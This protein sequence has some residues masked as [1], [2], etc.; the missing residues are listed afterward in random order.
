LVEEGGVAA[1]GEEKLPEEEFSFFKE[2]VGDRA[3][4]AQGEAILPGVT[5]GGPHCFGFYIEGGKLR[6]GETE[7]PHG[8]PHSLAEP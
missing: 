3:S 6:E 5:Q 7:S 1:E 2:A 4:K 8:G